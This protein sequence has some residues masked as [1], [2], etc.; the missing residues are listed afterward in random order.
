MEEVDVA[1]LKAR[2]A[3][4]E[5]ERKART[6]LEADTAKRYLAEAR[7]LQ[8]A[9]DGGNSLRE[10]HVAEEVKADEAD[11]ASENT[12]LIQ[13]KIDKERVKHS[14]SRERAASLRSMASEGTTPNR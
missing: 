12:R 9:I 6:K 5:T 7:D 3:G 14:D 4:W 1:A 8:G 2:R 13:V 11:K 10:R